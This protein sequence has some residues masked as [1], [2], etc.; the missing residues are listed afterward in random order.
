[1]KVGVTVSLNVCSLTAQ[2]TFF[3]LGREKPN[4]IERVVWAVT[5]MCL[6]VLVCVG[7]YVCVCVYVCVFVWVL[8]CMHVCVWVC[9]HVCVHP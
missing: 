6:C 9:A 3:L 4:I 2:T 7:V 1:M 8:M 5:V